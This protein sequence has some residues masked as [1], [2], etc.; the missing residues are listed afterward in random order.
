MRDGELY[1]VKIAILKFVNQLC[2]CLIHNVDTQTE[3]NR[4]LD[5]TIMS[6]E[7]D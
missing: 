6:N 1:C 7:G 5:R 4:D 2:Q 3:L